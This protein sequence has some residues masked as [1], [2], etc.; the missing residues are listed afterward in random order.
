MRKVFV[1]ALLAWIFAMPSYAAT[2]TAQK[3]G[4]DEL[5][6]HSGRRVLVNHVTGQVKYLWRNSTD[7]K[8]YP[9]GGAW[10]AIPP[11]YKEPLQYE[12]DQDVAP[13]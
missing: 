11:Q 1:I 5:M 3:T 8:A 10:E 6:L 12:Y 2:T 4:Y 9:A 13:K 7:K